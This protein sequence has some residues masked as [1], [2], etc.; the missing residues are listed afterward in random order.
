MT[1]FAKI[2]GLMALFNVS[3]L[4]NFLHQFMFTKKINAELKSSSDQHQQEQSFHSSIQTAA[5]D[6]SLII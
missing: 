3:I 2:G 1:T 4:L 6:E 5:E